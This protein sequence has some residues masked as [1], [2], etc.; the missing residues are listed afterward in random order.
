MA[1]NDATHNNS[2]AYNLFHVYMG[3]HEDEPILGQKTSTN[4]KRLKSCRIFYNKINVE[5]K[6]QDI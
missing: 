2:W 5:I 4:F 1:I 3:F 6:K